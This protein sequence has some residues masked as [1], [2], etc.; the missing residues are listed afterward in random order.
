MCELNICLYFRILQFQEIKD[1]KE[2]SHLCNHSFNHKCSIKYDFSYF[3]ILC[4]KVKGLIRLFSSY[5]PKDFLRDRENRVF[6]QSSKYLFEPSS[7][8]LLLLLIS[9]SRDCECFCNFKSL[10]YKVIL[11]CFSSPLYPSIFSNNQRLYF[12]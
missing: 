11:V 6:G 8:F 5:F 3:E 12:Q 1:D 10:L 7:C 4:R 2:F 9:F